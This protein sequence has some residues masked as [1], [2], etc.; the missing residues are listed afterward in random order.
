VQVTQGVS[1]PTSSNVVSLADDLIQSRMLTIEELI[2]ALDVMCPD[3]LC[4]QLCV[5]FVVMG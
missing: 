4:L 1:Q 5:L 2:E 3:I